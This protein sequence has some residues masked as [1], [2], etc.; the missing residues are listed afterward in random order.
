MKCWECVEKHARDIEHHLEDIV[1][2]SS[3]EDRPLYEGWIDYIRD[4]RKY[5]HER[6]KGIAT[7]E[8]IP[9]M[10]EPIEVIKGKKTYVEVFK[11]KEACDPRSFRV[12]KPN[13]EH[14]LT[15]CCPV[16]YWNPE[17]ERCDIGTMAHKLEHLH[18]Y[19]EGGCPI[20]QS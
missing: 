20:C 7:D 16:G 4:I 8:E 17:T 9:T 2:V 3:Q 18:P 10:S 6:A 11:P 13:P 19:G 14:I 5:A 1:R 12:I 15:I